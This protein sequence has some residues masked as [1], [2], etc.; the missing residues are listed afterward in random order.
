MKTKKSE[1]LFQKKN[2][3]LKLYLE[4]EDNDDYFVEF[5][6]VYFGGMILTPKILKLIDFS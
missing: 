1:R 3:F 2:E 6:R 5:M 4:T